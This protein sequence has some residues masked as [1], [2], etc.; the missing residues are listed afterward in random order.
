M[1]KLKKWR[2]EVFLNAPYDKKFERLFLA[3]IAGISAYGMVPRATLEITDSSRRL[4]KILKLER[5]CDY[6]VHD[7]SRVQLDP[8]KPRV[9]RFKMPFELGLCVADATRREGQK[10]NWFVFEAVANRVDKSLSDLKGTDPRIHGT[11]VQGVLSGLCNAFRRPGRQ[12]T[13]PQMMQIYRALRKNQE[14]ILKR[15]GSNTLYTRRVFADVCVLASSEADRI[16]ED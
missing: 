4:E 7:L 10:Q 13:V 6:S 2:A 5:S 1:A 11:T 8:A 14:A 12:P 15:A 9:P 3:Y 16:V